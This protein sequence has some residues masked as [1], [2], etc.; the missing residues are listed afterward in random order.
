MRTDR[1]THRW[2]DERTD[3]QTPMMKLIVAL[4]NFGNAPKNDLLARPWNK[5]TNIYNYTVDSA[6]FYIIR[7]SIVTYLTK[8]MFYGHL[9]DV[10]PD[11]KRP[12]NRKTTQSSHMLPCIQCLA[13]SCHLKCD[14]TCCE[15]R[16]NAVCT[17]SRFRHDA[18]QL[19]PQPSTVWC[20]KFF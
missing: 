16:I 8:C 10:L 13:Q 15:V 19:S 7:E 20:T 18:A 14:L 17:Q 3:R 6:Y 2:M 12:T 4:R 1:Q 9:G 11:N 5:Q